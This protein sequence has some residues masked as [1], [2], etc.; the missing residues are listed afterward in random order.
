MLNMSNGPQSAMQSCESD[1]IEK[2]FFQGD[3]RAIIEMAKAGQAMIHEIEGKSE[4]NRLRGN[5]AWS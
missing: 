1:I 2:S 5:Q 4:D 3:R